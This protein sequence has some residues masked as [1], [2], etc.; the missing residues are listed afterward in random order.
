MVLTVNKKLFKGHKITFSDLESKKPGKMGIPAKD[1]ESIIGMKL[2][3]NLE[4]W[5]FLNKKNLSK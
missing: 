1:F 2:N 5:D 3:S 4:K